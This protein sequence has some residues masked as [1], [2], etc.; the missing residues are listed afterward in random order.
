MKNLISSIGAALTLVCF[1]GNTAFGATLLGFWKFS[2]ASGTTAFDSSGNGVNGT[3]FGDAVFAPGM[4][5]NGGGAVSITSTGYVSMG[6]NFGFSGTTSFSVEAWIN[7]SNGN[8]AGM[9]PVAYHHSTQVAGYFLALNDTGDGDGAAAVNHAHVY[10]G[11]SPSGSFTAPSVITINDGQWHQIV[12]VYNDGGFTRLYVDGVFQKSIS[13][14]PINAVTVDFLVGGLR[15]SANTADQNFFSG[16]ISDVGVWSGALSASDIAKLF[17]NPSGPMAWTFIGNPG[18]AADIAVTGLGSV[19]GYYQIGTYDVTNAQYA[20]FLNSKAVSD[21]L[22]LYS[23][24]MGSGTGGITQSGVSGSYT[25]GTIAGRENMPVNQVDFYDVLRFANWMNNGQGSG[26][27]ETG[28]YTL[29]GGTPTPSNGATVTRNAGAKIFLPS[30][31]EWYKA[32]YYNSSTASY[33]AYPAGSSTPTACATPT[34]TPNS[35]NCQAAV[36]D[37]TPV[38]GYTGS[39]SPY[40]T[41]DQGG[42]V[43]QWN[44]TISTGACRGF[45]GGAYDGFPA[46]LASSSDNCGNPTNEAASV[47]FRVAPEPSAGLLRIAGLLGVVG[48]AAWRRVRA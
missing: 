14:N 46:L 23:V 38:G 9:T 12:G 30:E 25:Y 18:N 6:N 37:L 32:A 33:F 4:G 48:L 11:V 2:E 21:P 1:L 5:P 20:E 17:A 19:A 39:A 44:E 15:N 7:I 27:T 29:L 22:G 41:F 45:R 8:A 47:G 36:G 34:A 40:G 28:A 3:L 16:R 24:A 26:D 42:N 13:S 35:A 43:W 31:S 10:A